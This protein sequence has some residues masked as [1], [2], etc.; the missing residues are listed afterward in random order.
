MGKRVISMVLLGAVVV[1]GCGSK[2]DANEENF[3]AAIGQYLDKHGELCLR[4]N[5]WPVDITHSDLQMQKLFRP[6]GKVDQMAALEAVGLASGADAEVEQIGGLDNKPTGHKFKVKRYV[7][8]EAGKKFYRENE[9]G[10]AA[11]NGSNTVVQGDVCY[12][13]KVLDKVVKWDAPLKL[14]DYQGT[15]VKYLY[16]IDGLADWAKNPELR[17]AF[18]YV[19]QLIDAAG[20]KEQSLSVKLTNLGWESEGR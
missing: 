9:V 14:G 13:K 6:T 18:P 5:K 17:A 2:L 15:S 7:L 4:L 16:R 19:G 11:H 3:G 1:T 10:Q 20:K 12:G 8:T